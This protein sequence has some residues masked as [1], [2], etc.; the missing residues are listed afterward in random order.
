M[1]LP[2]KDF[3]YRVWECFQKRER[4]FASFLKAMCD[5]TLSAE[6]PGTRPDI[7]RRSSGSWVG[8]GAVRWRA[9]SRTRTSQNI[10]PAGGISDLTLF[11]TINGA[12]K[13]K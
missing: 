9:V 10:R 5:L 12:N 1:L 6:P 8:V 4:L 13:E 2:D 7:Q 3:S 11:K